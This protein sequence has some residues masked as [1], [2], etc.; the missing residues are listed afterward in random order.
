M[1]LVSL[2]NLINT[3]IRNA[4][5]KIIKEEHADVD[6]AIVDE[7]F[8]TTDL[9]TG[10]NTGIVYE[11]H[12][13]KIGVFAIIQGNF[14]NPTGSVVPDMSI[15]LD[16]KYGSLG[17]GGVKA[18]NFLNECYV[19]LPGSAPVIAFKNIYPSSSDNLYRFNITYITDNND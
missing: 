3:N 14:Y 16:D 10:T 17:A 1:G 5:N 15:V 9:Y 2:T 6:Q 11:I 4:V 18:F 19:Y 7:L 8:K 13:V 12:A